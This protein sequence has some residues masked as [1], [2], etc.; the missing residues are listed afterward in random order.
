MDLQLLGPIEATVDGRP[1]RL[2]ATKQRAVL[3]MLALRV[4]RTVSVD[5]MIEGLWGEEIP[6]TAP[7]MVQ[8]YVSQLR[9]LVPDDGAAIVTHGRGYELRLDPSAVDVERFEQLMAAGAPR[10]ALALWRG[11]PLSDVADEPFAAAEIRRL[12]EL[13]LQAAEQ[14][15]DDDLAAGRHAEVIPELEARVAANPLREKLHAQRMLALY[16]CGRQADALAAYRD[17]RQVLVEQIG[18]EPGAE[19]RALHDAVLNQDPALDPVKRGPPL[20]ANRA[21]PR[22]VAAVVAALL[23][24]GGLAAFAVSRGTDAPS[25]PRVDENAVGVLDSLTGRITTQ[26][27][28]GR[29]PSAIAA[30]GGSMWVASENDGTVTRLDGERDAVVIPVDDHPAGLAFAAGSLW[31]VDDQEGVVAKVDPATNRVVHRIAAGNSPG[32]IAA[33]F[34]ALWV[35]SAVDRTLARIDLRSGRRTEIELGA[36][37][38]AVAAG[39]GAV[40]VTSEEGNV[41]FR[42]DPRSRAVTETTGVGNAPVAVA[43]G[44]RAV[45]VV[46]R[47]DATV[48]RIDPST[49]AVTATVPIGSQPD[50]IAAGA[51]GVWV[52]SDRGVTRIDP[53]TN[54]ASTTIDVRS[55][56]TAVA[57]ADEAVWTTT[58]AAPRSHRGGTLRVESTHRFEEQRVEAGVYNYWFHPAASLVYDGLVTYRR[59]GAST[60]G[61]VVADLATTVPDPS[62]DGKSYVFKLRSGIRFANGD[63]VGV[64]DVRASFVDLIKRHGELYYDGVVGVPR[65]VKKNR[66][67]DLSRGVVADERAGTITF[68]L[69]KPDPEFLYK[70]AFSFTWVAPADHPFG[71]KVPPPGTGPYRLERY[72]RDGTRLVR[73]PHFRVWSEDRPD[74]FADEIVVR[75]RDGEFEQQV[76]KVERG[77]AD[78]V[79]VDDGFGSIE[80]P[81]LISELEVRGRGQL[82]SNAV[83][84]FN[85]MSLSIDMPPLDDIRV[86]RALNY[87]VDRGAYAERA[88]GRGLVAPTCQFLPP[89]FPN[90]EPECR[91]TVDPDPG[92]AWTA[93]DLDRARRLIDESG[94]AGMPV[95]VS[96]PVFPATVRQGRFFVSLLRKLG[97]DS[98]LKIYPDLESFFASNENARTRAHVAIAGWWA[99]TGG[100]SQF[101]VLFMCGNFANGNG[102]GG[103]CDPRFD[104]RVEA[105][106]AAPTSEAGARWKEAYDYLA[107]VA[108]AVPLVNHRTVVLTSRRVGNY[109]FHPLWATL[110]DRIW[111]Q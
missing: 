26:Y 73:N 100:P 109:Q 6:D 55:R 89:G 52:T 65:C 86:R 62:P 56:P 10:D 39:A 108:A 40:W 8:L 58:L 59:A 97:Y 9:R 67:C 106:L 63:V 22:R 15:I 36:R 75:A 70:L 74:G 83:P 64:D 30:G 18:V 88:G 78:V 110:L 80:R 38:T 11:D 81:E 66:G 95:I 7:K 13:R 20:V 44:E 41:V 69:R 3:A 29:N 103:F 42:V 37:P 92:G 28:V 54:Q 12:E 14:A 19:L 82:F 49:H 48:M 105:A 99:D 32:A 35:T 1:V 27:A 87:A 84:S 50:A 71:G 21:P 85:F 96:T 4:N 45:W 94:T 5:R 101:A 98:R 23:A 79:V 25:L 76:A 93:P 102:S 33:G 91:Y 17:A 16:R 31:V 57:V 72:S 60:F 34:G 68:R 111:V 47:N 53:A 43:V 104:A 90:Y 61:T 2:G 24:A 107:D 46:N 77:E 51:G